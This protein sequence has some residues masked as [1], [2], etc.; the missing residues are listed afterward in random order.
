[1]TA[2]STAKLAS[3]LDAIIKESPT[4]DDA[5]ARIGVRQM[6]LR[7]IADTVGA[8]AR[9]IRV[10]DVKWSDSEIRAALAA[11][12]DAIGGPVTFS[13]YSR[14]VDSGGNGPSVALLM[15]RNRTAGISWKQMLRKYRLAHKGV[16]ENPVGSIVVTV[17]EAV[18]AFHEF[19]VECDDDL[20]TCTATNYQSWA[21]RRG[22]PS[23]LTVQS[24]LGVTRWSELVALYREGSSS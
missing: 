19:M 9:P 2:A 15:L 16:P 5:A 14:W 3:A 13:D 12:Q 4:W 10:H 22:R 8:T 6:T 1:M 21:T 7:K 24:R 17:D 11:A 20:M 23:R 18:A